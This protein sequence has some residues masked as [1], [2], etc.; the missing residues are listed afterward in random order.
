MEASATTPNTT[1]GK[2]GAPAEAL[3]AEAGTGAATD[4]GDG[5]GPWAATGSVFSSGS[6]GSLWKPQRQSFRRL[7]I[8]RPHLGQIHTNCG[9]EG[10]SSIWLGVLEPSVRSIGSFGRR[11][12]QEGQITAQKGGPARVVLSVEG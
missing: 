11:F 4:P 10:M 5:A 6:P 1:H 12:A 9:L 2:M 7:G 8:F 3:R